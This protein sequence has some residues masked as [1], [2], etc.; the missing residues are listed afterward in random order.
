MNAEYRMPNAE[1]Q[2]AQGN[3]AALAKFVIR[4][5]SFLIFTS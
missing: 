5:S 2:N 1:R 4:H 3:A